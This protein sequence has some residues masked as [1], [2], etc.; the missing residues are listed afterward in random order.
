MANKRFGL[1]SLLASLALIASADTGANWLEV[2]FPHDSPVL[3]VTLSLQQPGPTT[4]TVRGASLVVDLHASLLLRNTGTKTLSGLT[5]LVETPD[6]TPAGRGSV[7]VPSLHAQPGEVFP[8]HINMQIARPLSMGRSKGPMMQLSLDCALFSD[9]TAY[10]PDKLHA[11]RQL[12]VYELQARRDRHYLAGLLEAGKL[13]QLREEL[14]FG[15]QDLNPAQLAFELLHG[16]TAVATNREQPLAVNTVAFPDAP[17]KPLSGHAEVAGNE[18]R[19]PRLELRNTSTRTV[20]NFEIGWIIRDDRGRDFMAGS[21]PSAMQV[22]PVETASLTQ[23]GTLRFS[24]PSGQPMVV[25]GLLAFVNDVEFA[26]GKLWIPSR[27]DITEATPDPVLRRVLGSSPE[28]QRLAEIYR[29]KGM[30]GLAD[31]LKRLD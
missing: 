7:T 20:K 3:P 28:Q 29:H 30:G 31:E 25:D 24:H 14:N 4:A 16:P 21:L 26:D 5:L 13:A 1:F 9:L 27:R 23:P 6:L 15:L 10:G 12:I 8:V 19:S 2:Q 22:G 11:R 18:V 17:L